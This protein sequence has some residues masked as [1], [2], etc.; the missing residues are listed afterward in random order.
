MKETR[1]PMSAP[2]KWIYPRTRELSPA[3][4]TDF[5][6][7]LTLTEVDKTQYQGQPREDHA[8]M[9]ILVLAKDTL[10]AL[11]I[12]RLSWTRKCFGPCRC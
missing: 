9:Y 11:G 12:T 4:L 2:N 10:G 8:R 5:I 6:N 1:K 7:S 3:R